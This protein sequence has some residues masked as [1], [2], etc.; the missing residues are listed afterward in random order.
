MHLYFQNLYKYKDLF[1]ELTKKD[2]KIKYRKSTLGI[3]WSMLNPLLMV[4]ILS[5]VFMEI[6]HNDIPNFP[7]YALTG[8]IIYQF[9]SEATN[10]AMDSISTNG[11]L[12]RKVYVPKYFF[13]L[14]R[15]CSSF[16]TLL[17]ELFPLILMML[18]TGVSFHWSN[19]L[20]FIPIFYLVIISAGIGLLLSSI[21]VFFND[22]RH[23]YS[24]LLVILMY[25]TPIFYPLSIIP[26]KFAILIFLNP[27]NPIVVIFRDLVINGVLPESNW[28]FISFV[29]ML[30]YGGIG[31]LVFYKTQNR[32]VYHL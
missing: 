12:I 31:L 9:F 28:H 8:R 25:M 2:I 7:I 22:I 5:I 3:V 24:I 15:I 26:D 17:I 6:F 18:F 30:I 20:L 21:N 27:L 13:P 19:L 16:V 29:N 14:S 10:F 1:F 11:Q 23:I 32:F 4:T